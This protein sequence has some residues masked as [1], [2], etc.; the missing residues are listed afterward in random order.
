M[1]LNSIY[2]K[3]NLPNR[4]LFL[5]HLSFCITLLIFCIIIRNDIEVYLNSKF[6][7]T[8]KGSKPDIKLQKCRMDYVLLC[9]V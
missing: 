3:Y 6:G 8:V 4:A 5:P 1:R 9:Y 7:N 2:D